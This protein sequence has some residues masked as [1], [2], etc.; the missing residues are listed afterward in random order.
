VA[1]G[2]QVGILQRHGGHP[3]ESIRMLG[4]PLRDAL[5]L[6]RHQVARQWTLGVVA[7]RV[8][9]DR[10]VVDPLRVHVDQALRA[11][12]DVPADVV[13]RRRGHGR[14]LHQLHDLG[15]EAVRVHVYRPD[16]AA[17]DRHLP[18]FPWRRA[19]LRREIFSEVPA[20]DQRPSGNAGS[21]S[22]EVATMVH[23]LSFNSC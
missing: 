4:A 11:E 3:H 5:V 6:K 9:V 10:L 14:V 22:K 17:V 15:N 7:P 8:H 2:G 18:P 23:F 21:M 16:P 1:I 13:L 12:H 20:R 19:N